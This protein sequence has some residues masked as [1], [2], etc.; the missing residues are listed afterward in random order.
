MSLYEY[1]HMDAVYA[2]QY[3]NVNVLGYSRIRKGI[4]VPLMSLHFTL[5]LMVR[6]FIY[7]LTSKLG[8]LMTEELKLPSW[9]W[10]VWN[11]FKK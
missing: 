10:F 9:T 6:L 11:Y 5:G 3:N 1:G 7:F 8:C 4:V 2:F